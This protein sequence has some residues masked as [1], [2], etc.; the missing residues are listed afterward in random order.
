MH[1]QVNLERIVFGIYEGNTSSKT[2]AKLKYLATILTNTIFFEELKKR[3]DLKYA[4]FIR[5]K[6]FVVS[7]AR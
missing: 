1:V 2:L 6:L 7:S 3:M 5:L 4:F